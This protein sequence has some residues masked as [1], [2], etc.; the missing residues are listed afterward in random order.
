ML[1]S[2]LQSP[3]ENHQP[4]QDQQEDLTEFVKKAAERPDFSKTIFRHATS[5]D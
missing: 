4:V 1:P 2:Q 5:I 3:S